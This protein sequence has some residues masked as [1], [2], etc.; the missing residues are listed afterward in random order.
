MSWS[1]EEEDVFFYRRD[2]EFSNV[3]IKEFFEVCKA[4]VMFIN[5][6]LVYHFVTLLIVVVPAVSNVYPPFL[7]SDV[8]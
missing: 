7:Q 1:A 2:K 3:K 6:D 8:Y 4:K 5:F